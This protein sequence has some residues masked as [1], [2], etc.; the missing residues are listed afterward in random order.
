MRLIVHHREFGKIEEHR[1]DLAMIE[2]PQKEA[3]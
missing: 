3:A 2:T 1:C